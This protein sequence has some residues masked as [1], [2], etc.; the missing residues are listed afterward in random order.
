M[1]PIR[2][3]PALFLPVTLGTV[4][5]SVLTSGAARASGAA[6]GIDML[7]ILAS[8][9]LILAGARLG[10]A[11]FEAFRLPAV[12]GE[13]VAGI[14]IGNV[15]LL[16]YH[17]FEA[18]RGDV[19]ISILAQIGVL[20]LLFQV[21]LESDVQKMLAVGAS[22]FLVALLGVITPMVL[23]YFVSRQFFPGHHP[24]THWFVGA[25]LT[26]T[27]VG[28][29]AR[30]LADLART[31]S[32]E[33]RIIL[34]AA[35]IDDVMGLIVL[36]VVAG[37]I[38]AADRGTA[39][40]A[41]SVLWVVTRALLFLIGAVIV[42]RWLSKSVF[43][44]AAGLRGQ[45]VL[46]TVA[47]AFCFGLAYLAG[48][49]GLAPIVGAFAAGLVLDEVHYRELRERQ[50]ET[51]SMHE[52]LQPIAT[53]LVPIFFVLMG[54]RV[55]LSSFTQPGVIGFAAALTLV[56]VLGKQACSLGVLEKGCDRLAV[57]LG[58]IPRGEVGLI[59]AGIGATLTIAGERVVDGA[60][61]SAVVIMVALTTLVTPPLLVWR[62]R[63]IDR[64]HG[65][66]PR[67]RSAR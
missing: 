42:G 40:S 6:D 49:A 3:S 22:S 26:A 35:V 44:L 41:L 65:A 30:V 23:G 66:P 20:F 67:R 57:G 37:I 55:D 31:N 62:L 14:V 21:G 63:S 9:L 45:G 58:M 5:A 46:L 53:F 48:R 18:L 32:K 1:R 16:G 39:F 4:G 13:L 61:F 15:G 19:A 38:E 52:L 59:F 54:I 47:L 28:I 27:S 12:L 33:G 56:A 11:L 60:V 43:G 25:T 2:L 17:R 24:L 8:L 7:P 34:G 51:R 10:G 64:A 50:Q 36:A 29:T